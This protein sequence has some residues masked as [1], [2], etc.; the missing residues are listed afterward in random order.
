MNVLKD[1]H[2]MR[3][4]LNSNEGTNNVSI[5]RYYAGLE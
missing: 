4:H 1:I 3:E 5:E 2:K